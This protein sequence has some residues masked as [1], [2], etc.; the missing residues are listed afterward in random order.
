MLSDHDLPVPE[1][2]AEGGIYLDTLDELA[3]ALWDLD[4]PG[5]T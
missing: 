1:L 3:T 2:L 4:A 5:L